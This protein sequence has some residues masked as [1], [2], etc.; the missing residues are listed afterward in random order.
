MSGSP[1]PTE[2]PRCVDH[3]TRSAEAACLRCGR[4]ICDWCVKLAPSWAPASH[5]PPC[6]KQFAG[7]PSAGHWMKG[8]LAFAAV[9]LVLNPAVS[10]V[11]LYRPTAALPSMPASDLRSWLAAVV[12]GGWLLTFFAVLTAV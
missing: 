1:T 8:P 6:Q 5:C 11:E 9:G 12:G 4:F 3:P 7:A 2:P 10:A